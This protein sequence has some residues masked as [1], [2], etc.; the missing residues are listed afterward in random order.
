MPGSVK[1]LGEIIQNESRRDAVSW[2]MWER[3]TLNP[4]SRYEWTDPRE[5]DG[6]PILARQKMGPG[7]INQKLHTP[8]DRTIVNN[9][10]SYF[11]SNIQVVFPE[12]FPERVRAFYAELSQRAYWKR[13]NLLV[14][15]YCTD[16]G[17]SYVLSWIDNGEFKMR[18]LKNHEAAVIY[19]ETSGEPELAV[20]YNMEQAEI[21]D[22][23]SVTSYRKVRGTWTRGET[24]LHGLGTR[25]RPAIPL[26]EM[27]NNPEMLGNPEMVISLCDAHDTSMSDLSS[28]IA[29]MRLAYLIMKGAGSDAD[30]IKKDLINAGVI[31]LE[32]GDSDARFITKDLKP[33]AVKILQESLRR[34]I[35]EGASSYDPA[36]FTEGNPPTA[37]EIAQRLHPLEMD[38][39]VTI[40]EWTMGWALQDYVI[41]NYLTVHRGLTDYSLVGIERIFRRVAPRNMLQALSDAANAGITLSNRTKIEQSGL[42]IDPIQEQARLDAAGISPDTPS[43]ESPTEIGE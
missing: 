31:I 30:Q 28:E 32:S 17:A 42:Q 23:M 4:A 5:A 10:V 40:G 29:Q 13:F 18:A 24:R 19:N 41:R 25:S 39:E 12:D 37:Y 14:A 33:E 35:F 2:G 43:G 21:Y 11:A 22:G 7:S 34:L 3:Y 26:V 8:F 20:R 38:V 16:T 6:I 27:R 15:K 36:T 9:K 1:I